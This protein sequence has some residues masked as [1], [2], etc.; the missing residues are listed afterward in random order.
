MAK[1]ELRFGVQ[2]DQGRR[3]A[4][5][6][7]WTP[8]KGGYSDVYLACRS[9]GGVL[10]TSLH[11]SG[12]WHIAYSKEAFEE[13][14]EGAIPRFEDRF[15]EK[16]PRPADLHAGITLAYR[17]VTPAASSTIAITDANTKGVTWIPNAPKGKATE[18][19]VFITE[20]HTKT[21]DWPGKRGMGTLFIGSIEL[22]NG[23]TVWAV[24]HFV[25]MP[26]LSSLGQRAGHYYKG[27][28]KQDID[29]ALSKGM[30]RAIAYGSH[31][32]GSRIIYDF[33][34]ERKPVP[35]SV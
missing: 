8:A 22:A 26:D 16:W 17:I 10:K 34:V 15:V 29:D 5:W 23:S 6:K 20:P 32:D 21:T 11:E 13:H 2:D 19:A 33:A 35:A 27:R 30:L 3:A 7:L 9:L 28:T 1:N 14:V 31:E 12:K 4:T 24:Y 18:I 25:D